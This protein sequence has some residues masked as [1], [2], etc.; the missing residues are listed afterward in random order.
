MEVEA[1]ASSEVVTSAVK[2]KDEKGWAP[3]HLAGSS[4]NAQIIEILLNHGKKKMIKETSKRSCLHLPEAKVVGPSDP[5]PR[6]QAGHP[7][8]ASNP[9][10]AARL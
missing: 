1:S 5:V 8:A 4:G 2:W 3:I 10:T 9:N 6:P 7:A